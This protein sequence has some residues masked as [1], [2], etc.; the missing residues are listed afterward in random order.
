MSHESLEHRPD[1]PHASHFLADQADHLDLIASEA[2]ATRLPGPN[3]KS[4]S[5]PATL[6][7]TTDYLPVLMGTKEYTEQHYSVLLSDHFGPHLAHAADHN[8]S[9]KGGYE[10]HKD[11]ILEVRPCS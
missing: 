5:M 7:L 10:S 11:L 4:L 2:V 9:V 6:P 1:M 3:W 8:S